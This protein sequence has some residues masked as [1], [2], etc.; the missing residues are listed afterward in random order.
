MPVYPSIALDLGTTSIKGGALDSGGNLVV[1]A[2]RPAPPVSS[3]S[4]RFE[5]DALAYAHAAETVLTACRTSAGDAATLGLCCQRSSFLIWERASGMPLT[6]LISWQDDRGRATCDALRHAEGA[7]MQRTGLR[8]AAYYLAPKLRVLLSEHPQ[9]RAGLA[10][11]ELLVGTL[12]TFLI[13]RWSGGREFITDASMAARTL[14]MDVNGLRWSP[15]LCDLFGIPASILAS[16]RPSVGLGLPLENGV[17]LNASLAD[18]S[19]ALIAS[20]GLAGAGGG[21]GAV[22]VN[23]GTG[24]FGLR[25]ADEVSAIAPGY[26]RTLVYQDAARHGHLAMEGTLNSLAVALA[27]YPVAA[28]GWEELAQDDIFC[29]AE[30]S[31]LGAPYFRTDLGITFSQPVEGLPPARIGCLLLEGIV[32]RVTRML[33]DFQRASA[34]GPVFLS[35]GLSK[36]P[37]LEQGIAQCTGLPVLHLKEREASLYGTALLAAGRAGT[38]HAA[39]QIIVPASDGARLRNKYVFWK[40]WLDALLAQPRAH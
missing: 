22:L 37:A 23:L 31:G 27:P 1:L 12:D 28:C 10:D 26:L 33:E 7:I 25:Y 39:G 38:A 30:P 24:G 20:A 8:L 3:T 6:P 4:G 9:L 14:L 13:W 11:G 18:Q 34:V 16:I 5:S 21:N 32:F 2:T 35:G 15:A 36:L 40:R 29:L 17:T 19:A